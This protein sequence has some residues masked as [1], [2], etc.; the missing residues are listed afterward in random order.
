MTAS[1]VRGAPD[2]P[3]QSLVRDE[4]DAIVTAIC[5]KYPDRPRAEIERIVDGAYAHLNARARVH[6]HLVPLTLNRSL[7]RMRQLTAQ[8][9]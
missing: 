4:L 3:R 6:A 9:S 7:R 1:L 5:A 2:A 8:P